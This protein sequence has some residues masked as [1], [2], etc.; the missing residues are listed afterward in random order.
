M[1]RYAAWVQQLCR[2][3]AEVTIAPSEPVLLTSQSRAALERA[4]IH[5][6]IS[7]LR[8]RR[9][10]AALLEQLRAE[11]SSVKALAPERKMPKRSSH[12]PDGSCYASG[13][14]L[15]ISLVPERDCKYNLTDPDRMGL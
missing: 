14:S 11:D 9:V 15:V 12:G 3:A 2:L 6:G 8:G 7:K 5:D 1:Q 4:R 13:L 10:M